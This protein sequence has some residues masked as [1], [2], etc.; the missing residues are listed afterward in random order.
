MN[1]CTSLVQFTC[2]PGATDVGSCQSWSTGK[3][4]LGLTNTVKWLPAGRDI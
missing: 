1:V 3:A 4:I 2:L